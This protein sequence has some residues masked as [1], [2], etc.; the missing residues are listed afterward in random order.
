MADKSRGM[1]I[2]TVTPYKLGNLWEKLISAIDA[3]SE[4]KREWRVSV[5]WIS[6]QEGKILI[7]ESWKMPCDEK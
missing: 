7:V 4:L 3:N 5:L 1:K 6:T 2:K